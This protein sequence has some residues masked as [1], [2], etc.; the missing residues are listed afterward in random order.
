M[1]WKLSSY[2]KLSDFLHNPANT[3]NTPTKQAGENTTS[4]AEVK[5]KVPYL[6]DV[7]GQEERHK[8]VQ[9]HVH[10][11]ELRQSQIRQRGGRAEREPEAGSSRSGPDFTLNLSIFTTFVFTATLKILYPQYYSQ[12][13]KYI[14]MYFIKPGSLI[15]KLTLFF[16]SH[17]FGEIKIISHFLTMYLKL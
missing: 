16:Y 14:Y 8:E 10:R 12:N 6:C 7:S 4:L 17:S 13:K 9:G 5:H 15:L 3:V 1:K 2:H 11:A